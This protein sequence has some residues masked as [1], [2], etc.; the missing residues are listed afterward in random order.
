MSQPNN[1]HN[2]AD[3]RRG[4][5]M[6]ETTVAKKTFLQKLLDGVEIVGNKVPHPAVIFLLMSAIVIVLSHIFHLLGT[7][8]T[9][10]VIDPQTH[11]AVEHDRGRQQPPDGGGHPLHHHVCH[12]QLPGLRPGRRHPRGH[13][14]RGPCGRGRPDQRA[15][16][17]DRDRG[18]AQGDHLHHRGDGRA[19]E[20]RVR[21]RLSGADSVGSR[22]LP[23]SGQ[24]SDRGTGGGI[25]RR[26]RGVRR[27]PDHHADRRRADRDHQ[28]RHPSAQSG[29]LDLS[30]GEPVLF[31]RVE[32]F[33]SASS[34]P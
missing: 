16:P 18:A 20:R 5:P 3:R 15:D 9:Y 23:E 2:L 7:S 33:C 21:R 13:G 29:I 34:A 4:R 8:V 10:Q 11:K 31:H 28:R 12:Q 32:P 30:D 14:G 1:R 22:R 25:R 6:S 19:V 27:E 24:A 26:C 17:Q